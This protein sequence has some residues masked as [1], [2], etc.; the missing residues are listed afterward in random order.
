[1]SV[2]KNTIEKNR[3]PSVLQRYILGWSYPIHACAVV[4]DFPLINYLAVYIEIPLPMI[5]YCVHSVAPT[6]HFTILTSVYISCILLHSYANNIEHYRIRK[7]DDGKL[8]IDEYYFFGSLSEIVKVRKVF[9][10]RC[11]VISAPVHCYRTYIFITR[12]RLLQM[13]TTR[14]SYRDV[15]TS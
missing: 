7:T 4:A 8:T 14:H 5:P 6:N 12:L 15:M 10:L 3:S 11:I 2:S 1:M 13:L 9:I